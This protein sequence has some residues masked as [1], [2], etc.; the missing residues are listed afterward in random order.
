MAGETQPPQLIVIAGPNGAG[1]TSFARNLLPKLGIESFL[2]ADL[3][4]AGLSPLR[5][6]SSAFAAG[7]LLLRL[8]EGHVS[9]GRDFAV[10]ST[11]SGRTYA[12][13]LRDA[14]AAGYRVS[15]HYLWVPTVQICLRRIRNRVAKGGHQVPAGDVRRRYPASLRNF[16]SLYRPLAAEASLWD[17][18][19]QPPVPVISWQDDHPILHAPSIH[20]RIQ[21]QIR[22]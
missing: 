17:V 8:W 9:A 19:L 12:K 13:M 3:I 11:L 18:S 2:N 5:P 22:I 10:E 16:F 15:I 21:Q 1:K 7:R 6:E 20:A 14:R 4:A